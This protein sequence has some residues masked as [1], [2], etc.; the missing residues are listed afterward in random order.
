MSS[1]PIEFR[2]ETDQKAFDIFQ[3]SVHCIP[4][5]EDDTI[6]YHYTSP[7]ALMNI[8]EEQ[9]LWA[10]DI[11]YLNDSSELRH[12]YS[13]VENL[14]KDNREKWHVDFCDSLSNQCLQKLR[15]YDISNRLLF[16]QK[17][18]FYVVSFS[19]DPDNLNMWKHY[20]KTANSIGYNI[21]FRK[22]DLVAVSG[23]KYWTYGKVIY[24][25]VNQKS[26]LDSVLSKYEALYASQPDRFGR[27]Q[28][29]QMVMGTLEYFSA[30]FKHP[31]FSDEREFR[32][33]IHN[34]I[35]LNR[36]EL[37]AIKYRVK[38]GVF[39]P[40]TTLPFSTNAV[41]SIGISPS[42]KQKIAEYSVERM[43]E[44][45]YALKYTDYFCSEIP[46]NP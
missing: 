19:L 40:Y 3:E 44:G 22:N 9:C 26:I 23:L 2:N 33:V 10:T 43:L 17:T 41:K 36:E 7:E 1:V 27:S 42:E 45:K 18:D 37:C 13:L 34:Q 30:F 16:A 28:V 38:D 11:N 46:F 5:I 21:G 35:R 32:I 4:E 20:T 6:V 29:F 25:E 14:V 15:K 39:I 31:A 8:T 12:T 24:D